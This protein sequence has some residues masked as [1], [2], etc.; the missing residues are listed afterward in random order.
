MTVYAI[1]SV[2][3]MPTRSNMVV[4]AARSLSADKLC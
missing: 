1:I 4:V 2:L 3:F